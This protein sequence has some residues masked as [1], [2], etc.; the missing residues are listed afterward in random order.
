M[1]HSQQLPGIDWKSLRL[2]PKAGNNTVSQVS[3][4]SRSLKRRTKSPDLGTPDGETLRERGDP[5]E[6][7]TEGPED[8]PE[9]KD[10]NDPK[11]GE[12]K[13][14]A[15]SSAGAPLE[16]DVTERTASPEATATSWQEVLRSTE[17]H[18]RLTAAWRRDLAMEKP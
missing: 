2:V 16:P 7:T 17:I 4:P 5:R 1:T 6:A 11:S 12:G 15:I 14:G 10:P 13:S 3:P 18:R 9:P 8:S